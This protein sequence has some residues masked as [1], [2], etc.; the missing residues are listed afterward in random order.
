MANQ[1]FV[2]TLV[3][4]LANAMAT[5]PLSVVAD[6]YQ[7]RVSWLMAM[8]CSVYVILAYAKAKSLRPSNATGDLAGIHAK[9]G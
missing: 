1:L 6:R 9:A 4:L 2:A 8:C 5:G 3:F 7:A